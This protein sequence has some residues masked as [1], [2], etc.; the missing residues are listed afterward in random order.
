MTKNRNFKVEV[1]ARMAMT[2]EKYTVARR[3]VLLERP[4]DP[5]PPPEVTASPRPGDAPIQ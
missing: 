1:R 4:A 2:G 3:A 5:T